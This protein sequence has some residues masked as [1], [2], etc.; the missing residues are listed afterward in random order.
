VLRAKYPGR[1]SLDCLFSDPVMD[2][3]SLLK[4][5]NLNKFSG[6][7]GV[8]NCQGAGSWPCLD[9]S[10]PNNTPVELSG[11]V[12]PADIELF[13][14][15]CGKSWTGDCAVFS[16]KAGMSTKTN[17]IYSTFFCSYNTRYTHPHTLCGVVD[18]ELLKWFRSVFPLAPCTYKT[19]CRPGH[20]R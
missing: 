6:V 17:C 11:K 13:E 18:H 12:S 1:P 15:V 3:K 9:T 10:A 5:W 7:I 19:K 2:G 4:I 14:E 16:F 20:T 8:F